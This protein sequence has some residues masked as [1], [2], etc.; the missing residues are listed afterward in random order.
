MS[1][2]HPSA[3]LE[4]S[5]DA[6]STEDNN[7]SPAVSEDGKTEAKA[8]L[9]KIQ[10]LL[11]AFIVLSLLW[12]LFAD[13]YTPYTNQARIE[14][15][16]VGV[17]PKVSGVVTK[18]FI[19]NNQLVQ[20]GAPLFE[21]DRSQY[22]IALEKAESDLET[23]RRQVGAGDANVDAASANLAAAKANLQKAEQDNAR[24]ERLHADDPGTVSVR[25]LEM[26]RASLEEAKAGVS[27][28][29]ATVRQAIEAKGGNNDEENALLRTAQS[30]VAK[31]QL[32]LKNTQITAETAGVVTDLRAEE[33]QF[34]GAGTP[35]VTLIAKDRIWL[36]AEFTENNLGR[37]SAGTRVEIT[38]DIMPGKVFRGSVES[39]GPGVSAGKSN[40]PGK[41]PSIDNDRDWLREAQRFPVIISLED[42]SLEPHAEQLR[43]GGQA[44][45]IAYTGKGGLLKMLGWFYIRFQSLMS[46][47]Y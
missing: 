11:L 10:R 20:A 5:P 34:S 24:L 15:F 32:D 12:Y 4:S 27:G 28:A 46:F 16:V 19:A 37:M 47:A 8:K 29:E 2:E 31:A 9:Q 13:R 25:R 26:S 45:V 22:E 14:G 1:E 36:N 23:A 18:V 42:E 17:A 40:S 7:S 35:V 21:I 33:G 3:P 44:S 30:A 41:L 38:F 43:I 39:I 6:P